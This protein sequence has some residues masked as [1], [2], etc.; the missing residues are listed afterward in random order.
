MEKS[1]DDAAAT[2]VSFSSSNLDPNLPPPP[3]SP[4]L[5]PAPPILLLQPLP[6][7]SRPSDPPQ[8]FS[9]SYCPYCDKAKDAIRSA[10]GQPG[11]A[12]TEVW[13]LDER[14]DGG[15]VQAA[16]GFTGATTVPRVFVGGKFLGGG[17]DTARAAKDGTLLKLAREAGVAV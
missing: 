17:D 4:P 8:V 9:K 15:E 2:E 3:T 16:L 10:L 12:A 14:Q 5:P 1:D 7:S 6:S 11:I 13:E